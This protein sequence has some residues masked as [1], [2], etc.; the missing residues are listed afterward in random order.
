[1]LNKTFYN[2]ETYV[3]NSPKGLGVWGWM[4]KSETYNNK[5]DAIIALAEEE[6]Y[7][8]KFF[9][10]QKA[11]NL[12][13]A[14]YFKMVEENTKFRIASTTKTFT[15]A[16]QYGYSDVHAYEILKVIS[17]KTLEVR[18]LSATHNIKH[19]KT[20]VGGFSG[21]VENQ[22]NQKVTYET[23]ENAPVIR[24]RRNKHDENKWSSQG[25]RFTLE[26]KPYA[27]YDFN[28]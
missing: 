21:H 23:N 8:A 27:F 24:I 2:I 13:D 25:Q 10:K 1:M 22:H 28:F 4:R 3:I 6:K 18:E 19:L 15:H 12:T 7:T 26:T 14:K 9:A 20:Y 16:S 17:D 5:A 11:V